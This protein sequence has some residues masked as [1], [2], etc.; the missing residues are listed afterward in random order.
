MESTAH[1]TVLTFGMQQWNAATKSRNK[2]SE[3]FSIKPMRKK[4]KYINNDEIYLLIQY[5]D[6]CI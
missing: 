4:V 6:R 2:K 5:I 3:A 1:K